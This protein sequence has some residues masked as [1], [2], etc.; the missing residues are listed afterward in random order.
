MVSVKLELV[1]E[2][3]K[4]KYSKFVG[5]GSNE[6]IYILRS[7]KLVYIKNYFVTIASKPVNLL[8]YFVL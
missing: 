4:C 2:K 6:N 5:D 7:S 3:I 8:N 1:L